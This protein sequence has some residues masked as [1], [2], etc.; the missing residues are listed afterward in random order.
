MIRE[1]KRFSFISFLHN[2]YNRIIDSVFLWKDAYYSFF[3][4]YTQA[5]IYICINRGERVCVSER[6]AESERKRENGRERER[7]KEERERE[8]N[9]SK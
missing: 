4:V 7:E 6:E 1:I 3:A 9:E 8:T 2:E 5:L